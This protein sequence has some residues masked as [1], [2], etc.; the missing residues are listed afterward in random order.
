MNVSRELESI[1]SS[2]V[3][4]FAEWRKIVTYNDDNM[5]DNIRVKID[6]KIS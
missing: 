1:Q 6:S 4:V 2:L 3:E 5:K